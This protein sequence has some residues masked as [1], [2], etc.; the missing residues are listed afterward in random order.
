MATRL[1]Q[2]RQ[3]R[4]ELTE[5]AA[6]QRDELTQVLVQHLARPAGMVTRSMN[7]LTGLGERFS[8]ITRTK[9]VVLIPVAGICIFLGYRLFRRAGISASLK[10]VVAGIFS[11]WRFYHLFGSRLPDNGH[12]AIYRSNAQEKTI[13]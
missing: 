4:Q 8:A 9:P 11:V 5:H 12:T 2:I 7:I 3:R 1:D 10:A 6:V 13:R